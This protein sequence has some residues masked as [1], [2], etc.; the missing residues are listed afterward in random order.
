MF[1]NGLNKK[2]QPI[3]LY[4][5][6]FSSLGFNEFTR[7]DYMNTFKSISSSTATRDLKKGIELGLFNKIGEINKTK[8]I[9]TVPN[10]G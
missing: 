5:T 3:Y 8:H 2:G 7:K 10:N 1:F 6:Y 9:V 4:N